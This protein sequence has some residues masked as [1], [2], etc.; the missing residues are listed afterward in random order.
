MADGR[1]LVEP[2]FEVRCA[3]LDH[4]TPCLGY[5]LQEATHVNVWRNRL[6][7]LG[8]VPGPWLRELTSVE[9]RGLAAQFTCWYSN[10]DNIVFPPSTATLAGADNRLAPCLGHVELTANERVMGSCLDLIRA[11]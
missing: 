5:A 6:A 10:C 1:L 9:P 2:A 11:S 3:V 8:L 7:D 4:R